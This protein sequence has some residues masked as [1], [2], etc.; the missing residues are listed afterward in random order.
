MDKRAR[1]NFGEQLAVKYLLKHNYQIVTCH[2]QKRI[3]EIDIIALD[4]EKCLVFFE[5]KARADERFGPP[6]EAV[7]PA[8]LRKIIRTG[9]WFLKE[10]KIEN[11]K[12]RFDV[13]AIKLDN[14]RQMAH[15]KHFRNVTQASF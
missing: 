3:G 13:L 15:V 9:Y 5:V 7:T 12:F 6:E 14:E 4:P 11:Q 2:Y 8:K 10:K 1:G